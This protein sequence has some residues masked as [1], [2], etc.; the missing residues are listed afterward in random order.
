MKPKE[1]TEQPEL[2]DAKPT[3][4][5]AIHEAQDVSTS[6]LLGIIER[7]AKDTS[8]DVDKM[9][10]LLAM[11][12]RVRA[13]QAEMSFNDS[14]R[15][16]QEEIP[17]IHRDA[18]N[19]STNSH[20]ARL[21]SLLKIVVPIYTAHGFSLSFGTGEC[22][23]PGHYRI[24]CIVSHK[25][26]HS[27]PYQCDIPADTTGMKGSLNKT[28]TH[29]FGS[30]MSYGRRYLTLLVFN[31]AL[32]NEDDDGGDSG[33]KSSSGKVATPATLKWFLEQTKD[34]HVK[35]QAYGIDAG[36]I[37]PDAGLEDWPLTNVPTSKSELT[38]LRKKVE[39]MP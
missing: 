37:M 19:P 17:R 34:I 30:T 14:M 35:L 23:L 36:L 29:G 11:Y 8:T 2:V 24:T 27:R 6:S 33:K 26:G 32:V 9:E 10:K 5:V 13:S 3:E 39:A 21:E 22:P 16:V 18:V 20:Y 25:A 31:I 4:A 12:E 15:A 38:E 28:P 7:A 1:Q